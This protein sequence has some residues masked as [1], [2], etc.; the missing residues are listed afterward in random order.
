MGVGNGNGWFS[1]ETHDPVSYREDNIDRVVLVEAARKL[2]EIMRYKHGSPHS[3]EAAVDWLDC[4]LR[5]LA[6][7]QPKT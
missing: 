6:R 5:F 1:I 7:N 3:I 4:W 2:W